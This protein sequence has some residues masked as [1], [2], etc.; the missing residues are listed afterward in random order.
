[1]ICFLT[2]Y[3]WQ[4]FYFLC[5]SAVKSQWLDRIAVPAKRDRHKERDRMRVILS[6]EGKKGQV[7]KLRQRL[8][9]RHKMQTKF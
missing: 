6:T 8:V 9:E 2:V 1:M 3:F 5:V 4:L 7:Q